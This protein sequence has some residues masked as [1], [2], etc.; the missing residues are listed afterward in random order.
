MTKKRLAALAVAGVV[1]AIAMSAAGSAMAFPTRTGACTGCHNV[2]SAVVVTA[3]QTSNNG[4]TATYNVSVSN[5]YGDGMTAWAVFDGTARLAG[6]Y[7]AGTFSVAVGK[8]YKVYGVASSA[9]L[10]SN[11]INISP[12]APT[13]PP[14][15]ADTTPPTVIVSAPAAG[16]TVAGAVDLG[17]I[18][19]DVGSGVNRVEFRVDGVLVGSDTTSP[20]AATW[21]STGAAS[22][23]H[24]IEAKAYDNAGLSSAATVMVSIATPPPPPPPADT[25]APSVSISTPANGDTV[26]GSVAIVAAA[27]DA[28]SGVASVE[29]RV[30][31]V[32]VGSD[33]TLPYSSTWD[34]GSA[35]PGAHSIEVKVFDVAGNVAATTIGVSI[36]SPPPPPPADTTAPG[37]SISAPADGG[38]VSGT[39]AIAATASD[40]G[41]GVASVE[42]RVDGVLVRTDSA[43]PFTATWDSTSAAPGSHSIEAKAF[44]AAGNAAAT[45]I[46]VSLASPPPPPP[47]DTTAP[48]VSIVAPSDG[49][50]VAGTVAISAAAAD[51]GADVARVEFRVDGALVRTDSS[52]PFSATWDCTGAAPGSHVIEAKAFDAAGNAAAAAISVSVE[53]APSDPDTPSTEGTSDVTV[54]VQSGRGAIDEARV[55][56]TDSVTGE[57]YA[58]QRTSERGL[59]RFSDVPYGLYTLTVSASDYDDANTILVV[60]SAEEASTI[61]LARHDN[62][63]D[64]HE[65]RPWYRRYVQRDHHDD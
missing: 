11:S 46:G 60:D 10:G 55:V 59:A 42:F 65:D 8:T 52:A 58:R 5:T 21:D 47:A 54:S 48:S 31:G 45:T 38:T 14:P 6:A 13:P 20:F 49:G 30:D 50:T 36:A 39:V 63:G 40:A 43:A 41:S 53:S 64:S 44:D 16:A 35:A 57:R 33:T 9:G 32:L 61:T 3:T 2:D 19:S 7:N 18:A 56:L 26:A 25:T 23:L 17:A 28:E 62:H 27:A 4:T 12:T 34:S 37:V 51:S 15:P 22:G 24:T 1:F 29:F